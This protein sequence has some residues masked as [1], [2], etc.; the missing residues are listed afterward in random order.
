M[1]RFGDQGTQD[2]YN[3]VDS[4][5][6]R[7]TISTTAIKIARRKLAQVVSATKLADL[8]YP[9]HNHLEL[10]KEGGR[11]N[12]YHSIEINDQYRILFRWTAEGARGIVIDDYHG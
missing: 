10:H 4:K 6:A 1:E 2:V 11:Y 9:P 12:G 8:G 3:Q 7:R 5:P